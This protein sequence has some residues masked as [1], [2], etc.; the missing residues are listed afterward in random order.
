[1]KAVIL[2][3]GEVLLNRCFD[4]N[5]GTYYS[6]PGGGQLQG[7]AMVEALRR[8]CLEETGYTVEPVR[9]AA[10]MEEICL[11]PFIQEHYP[12]YAHKMLHIFV[13]RLTSEE[14]R[15]PTE[16]D[17]SQIAI[18]WV[19]TANIAS[20]NLLPKQ[21]KMYFNAISDGIYPQYLGT[22]YL[23]HNHG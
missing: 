2:R 15:K 9:F 23:E 1:M 4:R 17:E 10:L 3:N 14:Q 16:T 20:L 12:E 13:C 18:E 11:D 7:E 22:S 21:V 8:E 19:P 6:L 5:N